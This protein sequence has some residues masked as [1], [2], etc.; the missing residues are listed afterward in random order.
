MP[1]LLGELIS[2][3]RQIYEARVEHPSLEDIYFAY[4]GRELDGVRKD[5]NRRGEIG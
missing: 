3:G 5:G 2:A 1:G 4:I